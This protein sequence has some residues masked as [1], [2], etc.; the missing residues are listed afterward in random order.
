LVVVLLVVAVLLV[1]VVLLVLLVV[2]VVAVELVVVVVVGEVV[3][4]AEES[5]PRPA[6]VQM[7]S[8][9]PQL[10]SRPGLLRQ[11]SAAD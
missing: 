4:E 5:V 6:H 10:L 8:C 9:R 1:V 7:Q 2:A 11:T 3:G